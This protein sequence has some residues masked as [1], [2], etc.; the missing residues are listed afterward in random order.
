[1]AVSSSSAKAKFFVGSF[2]Y[3]TT[4]TLPPVAA[5][6]TY[7]LEFSTTV[8][9]QLDNYDFTVD[10]DLYILLSVTFEGETIYENAQY[11]WSSSSSAPTNPD[12]TIT[13]QQVPT[14]VETVAINNY[15]AMVT[16]SSG[17][18]S[19]GTYIVSAEVVYSNPDSD[20]VTDGATAFPTAEFSFEVKEPTISYW[21]DPST[22]KLEI[23]D[24]TS[25]T[26][27]GTLADRDT[28]FVYYPPENNASV[29]NTF[30]DIQKVVYTSPWVGG[31][32]IRY[33]IFLTYTLSTHIIVNAQRDSEAWTLYDVDKCEIFECLNNQY[34]VWKN[35]TCNTRSAAQSWE[36]LQQATSLAV[37]ILNGLGCNSDEL[38]ALIEEF[39]TLL[40]CD[41]DCLDDTP[42]QLGSS[43]TVTET[44]RQSVTADTSD[45]AIDLSAGSTITVTV[46]TNT[47]LD[48]S[49][50]E[51]YNNYR[52]IFIADAGS[53]TVSFPSADFEDE[54]GTISD[55]TLDSGGTL[56][57]DFYSSSASILSLVSRN[58]V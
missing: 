49:N 48:I 23:T 42:R 54:A 6:D 12:L 7:S 21:Y 31:N 56:I 11:G 32:E 4:L 55:L 53:E 37:Q 45:T 18:L 39:N 36:T 14:F 44:N 9:D 3:T 34:T 29:T 40:D 38:S 43:S 1:M 8:S 51:Q 50:I 5:E 19:S 57:M 58:D 26:L 30:D 2:D 47:T 20:Y 27:D 16:D 52:F 22:P 17:T 41:C 24:G 25:Y 10:P 28:E 13:V 35:S 15:K 46:S 33:T